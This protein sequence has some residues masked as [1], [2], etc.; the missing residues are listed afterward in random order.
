LNLFCTGINHRTAPIEFREKLWF[1]SEEI[2]TLLSTLKESS[3]EECVLTSTCNR[4]ELYYVQRKD[5]DVSIPVWKLLAQ[6][7]DIENI[8]RESHFY[9]IPSF[10]AVKHLYSV[11]T[12]IDSM[13]IGDV[14]ILSQIKEAF[15]MA[16]ETGSTG[17]LLNRLFT[18]AL[19]VGKRARTETEIGD[20][21]VSIGYAAAELASKIFNDLAKRSALLIGAGETAKLTAQ[22]LV[23]RSLGKLFLANRT[24]TR[25]EE[26]AHQLHGYVVDFDDFAKHIASVDIIITAIESH[27]YLLT[28]EHL[29]HALKE[30]GN[31][32]LFIIDLGVPRNIDPSINT[33]DNIFLHDIDALSNIVDHNLAHRKAQIHS[34]EEIIL[35]ELKHFYNWYQS[36]EVTPTIQQLNEHFE[37]IRTEE[38]AK[39]KHRFAPEHQE[40]IELLTRRI[41][42]KIL[43]TP[44]V[45]LKNGHSEKSGNT[46]REKVSILR[47]LFGLDKNGSR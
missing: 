14:Q 45:N 25:A 36:L 15:T 18:N 7:K 29:R 42:N 47:H 5:H 12:G 11:T 23:G 27:Q 35:H 43:H 21:A 19:H 4:T 24:R 13:I 3:M 9:N 46:M 6:S 17:T 26:L 44:I 33:I 32:P 30:R 28:T 34:V 10:H 20:G 38:I 1:S 41:V 22:H 37:A 40:E 16:Q 2:R 31:K 39:H 8:A